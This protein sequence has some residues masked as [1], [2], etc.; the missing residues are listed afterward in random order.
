[1]DISRV[2]KN[3]KELELWWKCKMAQ[4]LLK[5]VWQFLKMLKVYVP[6]NPVAFEFL[7]SVCEGLKWAFLSRFF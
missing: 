3:G 4:L 5:T 7:F 6:Y 1:M 2:S